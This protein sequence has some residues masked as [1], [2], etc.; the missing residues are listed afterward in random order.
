VNDLFINTPLRILAS[1][2][3]VC[4]ISGLRPVFNSYNLCW[5][6]KVKYIIGKIHHNVHTQ[7]QYNLYKIQ[8]K[9]IYAQILYYRKP[10]C[11]YFHGQNGHFK[12][13]FFWKF[14]QTYCIYCFAKIII[15]IILTIGFSIISVSN[16]IFLTVLIGKCQWNMKIS[17]NSPIE[18]LTITMGKPSP[19]C[20]NIFSA[21]AFV[22]VYVFG[23]PLIILENNSNNINVSFDYT[24]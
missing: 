9:K 24:N 23:H 6:K 21:K 15:I 5:I 2:N 18:G 11:T 8:H 20:N 22:N 1:H 7:K 4:S 16:T 12:I 3:A 19:C 14:T 13:F 17:V 10:L